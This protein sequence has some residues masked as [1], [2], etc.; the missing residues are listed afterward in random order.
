MVHCNTLN[1][2]PQCLIFTICVVSSHC[3]FCPCRLCASSILHY[4]PFVM[5][6]LSWYALLL[7]G[8]TVFPEKWWP[9]WRQCG[10]GRCLW[11]GVEECAVS[12][13]PWRMDWQVHWTMTSDL[14]QYCH[15]TRA[16]EI[17]NVPY[18]FLNSYCPQKVVNA[19]LNSSRTKT[20]AKNIVATES[21][22][23]NT[24]V[25]WP[26][27]TRLPARNS[28]VNEVEFLGLIHQNGGRPMRLRDR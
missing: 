3:V 27:R 13:Y 4:P 20:T 1:R 9:S 10:V 7:L 12:H 14:H 11:S 5:T 17:Q 19:A 25:L 23:R 16:R 24:V 6:W 21:D 8:L 2:L 15:K 26:A 18:F 22:Q 28:L